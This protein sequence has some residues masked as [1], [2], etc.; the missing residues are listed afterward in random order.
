MGWIPDLP[1][2]RDY[3]VQSQYILPLIQRTK[4]L[5]PGEFPD[6]VDLR[7]GDEGEEFFTDVEDQGALN[8]SSAFA[9]LS[10]IEYFERRVH[11]RTFDGSALFLYKVT[12]YL[13]NK[14]A[15]V[16]GDTGADLRTTLKAIVRY[17]VP[18]TAYWPYDSDRFDEEPTSLAFH[19]A[20]RTR[21][22]RY[23]R[24]CESHEGNGNRN[25]WESLQA[26]L[27]A[28]FPVVFGFSVPSSLSSSANI[29]L[30]LK[31]D[32]I[33]GGQ[34]VVAV[35]YRRHCLG[36]N[37]HAILIRSSWG[38]QWGDNGYGWLPTAFFHQGLARD[39]WTMIDPMAASELSGFANS[40]SLSADEP[41]AGN[42]S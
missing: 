9:V 23:F 34:A 4:L 35:G 20:E 22:L 6:E 26:F 2:S 15:S 19:S 38:R 40:I 7:Y 5:N 10:L 31:Y 32:S 42:L 3:T 25:E 37:Q 41:D 13:R 21:H 1:D 24:V 14:Q 17:G 8:S 28:G 36:R 27:A 33:R 12:R 11:G 18:D 39:F 30:R 29:P 16:R